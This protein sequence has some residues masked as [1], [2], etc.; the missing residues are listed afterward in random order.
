MFWTDLRLELPDFSDQTGTC[1]SYFLSSFLQSSF[2]V[3]EGEVSELVF[4]LSH[5]GGESLVFSAESQS[6]SEKWIHVMRSAIKLDDH[7]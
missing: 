5:P 7:H 3:Y 1:P 6:D 2:E 4:I